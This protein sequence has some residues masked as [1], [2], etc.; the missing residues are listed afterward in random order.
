MTGSPPGTDLRSGFARSLQA[1]GAIDYQRD[2]IVVLDRE[3]LEEASCEC[4][5]LVRG[6][7]SPLIGLA[8]GRL[9]AGCV[10][11]QTERRSAGD[12]PAIG[13]RCMAGFGAFRSGAP[14]VRKWLRSGSVAPKPPAARL[15]KARGFPRLSGVFG[16]L[17]PY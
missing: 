11:N 8:F 15:G 2:R 10:R 16:N 1:T 3:R 5:A 13:R 12:R 4:Y 6:A 17:T 9:G 7:V 14:F